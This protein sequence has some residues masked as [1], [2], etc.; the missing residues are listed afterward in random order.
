MPGQ[1]AGSGCRVRVPGQGAGSGCQVRVPDQGAGS[2]CRI[3]VPA[4][5]SGCRVRVPDQ[6]AGSGCWEVLEGIG[7]IACDCPLGL[8]W[9]TT[10]SSSTSC[11]FPI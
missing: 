5:G 7:I 3:R 10:S 6:G 2:G 8:L 9:Y 11:G 1:G 4:A